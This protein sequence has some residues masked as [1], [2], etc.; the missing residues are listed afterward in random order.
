VTI[1]FDI[2][3]D[4]LKRVASPSEATCFLDC[5]KDGPV[6]MRH[7][8]PRN[9]LHRSDKDFTGFD[10]YPFVLALHFQSANSG[11]SEFLTR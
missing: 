6:N 4:N 1:N 11:A 2:A 8:M 3:I 5:A 10:L 9:Y 7:R